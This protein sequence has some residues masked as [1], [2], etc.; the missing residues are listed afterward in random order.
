[1]L[2]ALATGFLTSRLARGV[3]RRT[4]NPLLRVAGMAAAG[5]V[6]NRLIR[7]RSKTRPVHTSRRGWS[8]RHA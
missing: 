3:N 5:Y 6:A 7:G 2:R 1:M 4:S 8:T